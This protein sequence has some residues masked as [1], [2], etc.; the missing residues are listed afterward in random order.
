VNK[1]VLRMDSKEIPYP[2]SHAEADEIKI[3]NEGTPL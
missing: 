3:W 2:L 1:S